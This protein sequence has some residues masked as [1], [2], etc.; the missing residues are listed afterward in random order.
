MFKI[1]EKLSSLHDSSMI[2]RAIVQLGLD[3][4]AVPLDSELI[5]A[6]SDRGFYPL[7]RAVA[8]FRK[9]SPPGELVVVQYAFDDEDASHD[10]SLFDLRHEVQNRPEECLLLT[11]DEKKDLSETIANGKI[12]SRA[13][14]R[15]NL[16]DG[17]LV[18]RVGALFES[19]S[20][21]VDG[22]L[23]ACFIIETSDN[24]YFVAHVRWNLGT[25]E[26]QEINHAILSEVGTCPE[27]LLSKLNDETRSYLG[28]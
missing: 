9:P 19:L 18:N 22:I 1:F 7:I 14:E 4:N 12:L 20:P 28:L 13:L 21:V 6:G 11:K 16:P 24:R 25:E 26:P 8:V 2:R 10:V 5:T 17:M 3:E 23:P 27:P 15:L